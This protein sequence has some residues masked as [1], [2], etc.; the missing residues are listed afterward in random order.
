DRIPE[1]SDEALNTVINALPAA[2]R[3][4]NVNFSPAF[5]DRAFKVII[6]LTDA[7]PGGFDD[8]F[9][10]GVDDAN[11]HTFAEQAKNKNIKISSIYVPTYPEDTAQVRPI[12]QDYATTTAGFYLETNRD[13]TG[14]ANA[15]KTIIAGCGSTTTTPT[16][17]MGVPSDSKTGSVLFFNYY[18]S[19]AAKPSLENT[20]INLANTDEEK[21]ILVR[22]SFV[23]SAT[24]QVSD[25]VFCI[26]AGRNRNLLASDFDPGNKGYAIAVAIGYNGCPVK[27]NSLAGSA[28][29]KLKTGHQA[30]LNAV[31]FSALKDA[32]AQCDESEE[33]NTATLAFDGVNYDFSPRI[34]A[35]PNF[36]SPSDA[37]TILIINRFGGNFTKTE[38]VGI[39]GNVPAVFYNDVE[40][41][42][43]VT[44][45]GVA[46]QTRNELKDGYPRVIPRFSQL[47]TTG[48]TGWMRFS[49][50]DGVSIIGATLTY[51]P[52][53]LRNGGFN[54]QQVAVMD[55]ETIVIPHDIPTLTCP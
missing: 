45:P 42:Y 15:I 55:K 10:V 32:P 7:V 31:A 46:C 34:L 48:R 19:D 3:P 39:F 24:C 37:S 12:M 50:G 43:N 47:I 20:Q 9:V 53:S 33:V 38:P 27:F 11:A 49:A 35:I 26:P 8:T 16:I 18:T 23:D 1:A 44:L 4:Q 25:M 36:A 13:G 5:R 30:H 22:F 54:L 52:N 29:I 6:L 41:A 17:G 2:G 51:S 40:R 21:P 14:T 28:N